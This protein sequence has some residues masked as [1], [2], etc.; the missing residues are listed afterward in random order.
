MDISTDLMRRM[1]RMTTFIAVGL[2]TFGAFG[3]GAITQQPSAPSHAADTLKVPPSAH[4]SRVEDV[5][6]A[7]INLSTSA[8][9]HV[10]R[11]RLH[12][13]AQR[14][15]AGRADIPGLS[16]SP[17]VI[18]C[19]DSTVAGAL[20]NIGTLQTKATVRNSVTHAANVSLADLDLSTVEG[21]RIGHE[22]LEAM[23]RRLCA[24]L[25]RN[26]DLSYQPS[27][28]ACVPDTMAGAMAQAKVLAAEREMRF[29]RRLA[30]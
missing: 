30:P 18:A 20:G 21:S 15:C 24:E 9:M 23:A 10:A 1:I 13:M 11:E 7:D 27:W 2:T 3:A 19:V 29:A 8:G 28:A 4:D 26:R 6:L 12:A 17:N 16:S 5:S 14:I 22:R 25:A